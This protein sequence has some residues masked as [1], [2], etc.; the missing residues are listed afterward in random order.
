MSV[1]SFNPLE[2]TEYKPEITVKE[3]YINISD[4]EKIYNLTNTVKTYL[5]DNQGELYI[6]SLTNPEH[7]KEIKYIIS[8][9]IKENKRWN[10]DLSLEQVIAK[11]QEE[12]T[13]L[14]IIQKALD[15][16]TITNIDINGVDCTY[17]EQNGVDVFRPDIV[18][19]SEEH[20]YQVIDRL[21]LMEGKTL[22]AAEPHIDSF[23]RGFRVC[24]VLGKDRGG[25]STFGCLLSIRKFAPDVFSD[26][27]IISYGNI[28]EEIRNFIATVVPGGANILITGG[29]NSGKTTTLIRLPLYL[30]PS[31]R[32]CTIEDSPE[33]MLQMKEAYKEY[34][35][36]FSLEQKK[37]DGNK[38]REYDIAKNTVVALRLRPEWIFIGEARTEEAAYQALQAMNTGH[39][40]SMTIHAN[41]AKDGAVRFVQLAGNNQTIAAQVA[42]SLDIIIFQK[43]L[44]NGKRVITEIVEI[45]GYRGAEE[46]VFQPIFKYDLKN[47]K[48]MKV[49]YISD[50]LAEKLRMQFVPEEKI[51]RWTRGDAM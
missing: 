43:K 34:K 7:R 49:G 12:I 3:G 23:F 30:D 27:E 51:R 42:S 24:A 46:P 13:E 18:F 17:V 48:H 35:N 50:V 47:E 19:Q 41:S 36:I 37:F 9:F 14:G 2:Y 32:I 5:R 16:P 6:S 33:M 21:L 26:A 39:F 25:I 38:D 40:V 45:T 22:T 44:K 15:D 20:L 28:S 11:V 4:S 31:T 29:T 1:K 8:D 10:F